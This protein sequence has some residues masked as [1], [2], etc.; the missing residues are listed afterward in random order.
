MLKFRCRQ[1]PEA[2]DPLYKVK[3]VCGKSIYPPKQNSVPTDIRQANSYAGRPRHGMENRVFALGRIAILYQSSHIR[4]GMRVFG[5]QA[6]ILQFDVRKK[7]SSAH[8]G[9]VD[10]RLII[11]TVGA[12]WSTQ[13]RWDMNVVRA[14]VKRYTLP[15]ICR[16]AELLSL[17]VKLATMVPCGQLP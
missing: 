14:Q 12:A 8:I 2:K 13:V 10:M 11:P 7:R 17:H 4:A 9:N 6:H 5:S 3:G 16:L 1:G 15:L